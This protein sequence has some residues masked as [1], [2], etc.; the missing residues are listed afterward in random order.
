[1]LEIELLEVDRNKARALGI[2]PPA[3]DQLISLNATT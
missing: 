3:S 2:T 1:M